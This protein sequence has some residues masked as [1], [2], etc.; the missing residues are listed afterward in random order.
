MVEPDNITHEIL[1]SMRREINARLDVLSRDVSGIR[2]ELVMSTAS[3]EDIARAQASKGEITAVYGEMDRLRRLISDYDLR[4]TM[5]EP[6][7]T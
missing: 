3:R 7:E 2:H 4:I 5:L 6:G 1:K